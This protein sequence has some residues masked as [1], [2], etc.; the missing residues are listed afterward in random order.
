MAKG[1]SHKNAETRRDLQ[2]LVDLAERT[3]AAVIGIHHFTKG[4][5]ALDPLDRVSGS[6]AFGA[7][8]RV[9]LLSALNRNVA[10]EP[11]GRHPGQPRDSTRDD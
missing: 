2:P 4:S 10:G 11:R 6:L 3:H 1:D 8:P 5:E 7:G 9:V